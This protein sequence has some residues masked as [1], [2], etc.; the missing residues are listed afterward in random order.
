MCGSPRIYVHCYAHRVNLVLV[1]TCI[2]VQ[3][4]GDLIGLLQAIHNFVCAST[5]RHDKFVQIQEHRNE[6]VVEL[7]LQSDTRWVCKLKA[8][9]AFKTRFKAVVL[10]LEF[11]TSNGK[12]L[13]RA[14]VQGLLAQLQTLSTVC[15]LHFLEEVLQLSNSLSV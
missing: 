4:V 2:S 14:E 13:E 1:D 10:T 15:F 3:S 5:V 6:R 11:F 12:P 7:P 9:L 8:I